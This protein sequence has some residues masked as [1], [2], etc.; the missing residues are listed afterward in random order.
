MLGNFDSRVETG[1]D[2]NQLADDHV[3]LQATQIVRLATN[4]GLGQD[5]RR[6][7]EA[8]GGQEALGVQGCLGQTQHDRLATGRLAAL[9]DSRIR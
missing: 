3:L 9:F 6:L 4:G 1:A 2:R 7:L 8:G 5:T